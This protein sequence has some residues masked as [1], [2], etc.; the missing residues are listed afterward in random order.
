MRVELVYYHLGVVIMDRELNILLIE[1]DP[2]E[3]QSLIDC[4]D[5][6][7]SITLAAA[8]DNANEALEYVL[9]Y[10]PH[11]IILDLELHLGSGNGIAFLQQLSNSSL[12]ISPYILVNTNNTSQVTYDL[13]RQLG[14]DFIFSKHQSDYS[15][16]NVISFLL[17][18]NESIFQKFQKKISPQSTPESPSQKKKRLLKRIHAEL[19]LVGVNPKSVGYNYLADA[20]QFVLDGVERNYC[21]VIAEK[22]AKSNASIER[23]MQNA[24]NRAWRTSDIDTLC[25]HYTAHLS[26]DRGVPTQTEFIH[27]YANIIRTDYL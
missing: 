6:S 4:I 24:I 1:D 2:A 13:V 11:A 16:E 5:S 8:T 17:A 3:R 26:P 27:Y 7:E 21:I 14:A 23:A 19:N 18:I 25:K 22:Y 15:A 10:L 20:I 12:D 9:E